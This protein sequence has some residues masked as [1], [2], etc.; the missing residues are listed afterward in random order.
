MVVYTLQCKRYGAIN[1]LIIYVHLGILKNEWYTHINV[2]I[3]FLEHMVS[4]K[5]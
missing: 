1:P 4:P 3:L 2:S 5:M